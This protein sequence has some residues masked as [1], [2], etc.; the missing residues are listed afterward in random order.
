M[1]NVPVQSTVE[2]IGERHPVKVY[3]PIQD[4]GKI[5]LEGIGHVEAATILRVN[6]SSESIPDNVNKMGEFRLFFNQGG[7]T[8]SLCGG[9]RQVVDENQIFLTVEEAFEHPQKRQHFRINVEVPV[10]Y[11]K[12][13]DSVLV[14]E[15]RPALSDRV[16]LSAGGIMFKADINASPGE[17]LGLEISIPGP[18]PA[19]VRCTG[20][21]VRVSNRGRNSRDV[22]LKFTE[23]EEQ[24][25]EKI[26]RFCF[27]EQR[28]QLRKKVEVAGMK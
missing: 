21:I 20:E 11:W 14:P 10:K 28:Q 24:D 7:P 5:P 18:K 12:D 17:Y 23:I 22:A 19:T 25:Q 3:L 26:F 9:I 1:E 13:D 2:K 27:S 8:F 15:I 16:N 6:F 4:G